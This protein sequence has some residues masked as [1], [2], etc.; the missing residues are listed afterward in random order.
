MDENLVYFNKDVL[1]MRIVLNDIEKKKKFDSIMKIKKICDKNL[2][3]VN[4]LDD[5]E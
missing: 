4:M 1:K 3:V 2:C 5:C